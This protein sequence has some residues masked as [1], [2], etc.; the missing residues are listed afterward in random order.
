MAGPATL[1]LGTRA[2]LLARAQSS[3]VAKSL[4]DAHPGLRVELIFI[5]TTGDHLVDKSL[6]DAGGKGLFTKELELAL[7]AG[8]IDFAVHSFKDVPVTMPLVDQT[9]LIIASVPRR[10]DVRDCLVSRQAKTLADLPPAARVGTGSLRRRC[11]I[12]QHRPDLLVEPLRGNVD[13]RLR[14]LEAGAHHAIVLALAGL[15]R[16]AIFDSSWMTPIDPGIL[17]PAA[18]Q[19]ALALQC[20]RDNKKTL[21]F[22]AALNDPVT[23]EAVAAE[24][25]V[26]SALDGDC[27]SPIAALARIEGTRLVL[28]AALGERDGNPPVRR[29]TA[30]ADRI[31]FDQAVKAVCEQLLG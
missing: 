26:V 22:L 28:D 6:A 25:A 3:H 17:L 16:L 7:L 1:R 12:L 19:G 14:K 29:A 23:A 4:E 20:R 15:K 18:G 5:K 8:E 31:R 24:R 30:S 21:D 9:E 2:S 10:E 27:H 11:Q 13:T